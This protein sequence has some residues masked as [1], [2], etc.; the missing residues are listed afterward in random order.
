MRFTAPFASLV[1]ERM[2]FSHTVVLGLACLASLH[3]QTA[4]DAVRIVRFDASLAQVDAVVTDA[5][6]AYIGDLKADDFRV[7]QDGKTRKVATFHYVTD[8][9][10]AHTPRTIVFLINDG[11][12]LA[13]NMVRVRDALS[14][15]ADEQLQEG[16]KVALVTT[17]GGSGYLRQFLPAGSQLH[18]A[19]GDLLWRPPAPDSVVLSRNV[20]LMRRTIVALAEAPGRKSFVVLSNDM[21]AARFDLRSIAD[22]ASRA[23]VVVHVVDPSPAQSLASGENF[24]PGLAAVTGG[25]VRAGGLDLDANL[26]AVMADQA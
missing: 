20:E 14:R 4:D 12:M 25:L 23:S 3:A 26:R 2:A 5:R 22:A 21:L 10:K 17:M 19:I 6:G 15:F 8:G 16:D 7:L 9:G 24:L 1:I 18:G 13:T 11:N